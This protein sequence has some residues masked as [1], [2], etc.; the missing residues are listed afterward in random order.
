MDFAIHQPSFIPWPG[1]FFKAQ[2]TDILI[3]LDSVQFPRGFSW[4]NRNRIK[5]PVGEIWLT[6]PVLKKGLGLQA[7]NQVMLLPDERWRR[8]HLNT[9][10]HCYKNAPYFETLFA[11][12]KT[13]Y[14]KSDQWS[15]MNIDLIR[16]CDSVYKSGTK[17]V[18]QSELQVSGRAMEL[19]VKAARA[20]NGTRLVS[21][22][23]AR[24]H[25]D[26]TFLKKKGVKIK[27]I[28]YSHPVYPQLW[29]DF[30]KN[31]SILDLLFC[32]GPEAK[33]IVQKFNPGTHKISGG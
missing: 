18:K 15:E 22:T 7:I 30:I 13:I 14:Q 9:L 8:K 25:I 29:G 6:L 21:L 28:R 17:M 19:I 4:V 3:L 27:W 16:V 24:A 11:K 2:H 31:L 26:A 10:E 20:I 32:Y 23:S 5:G 33:T 12:I 1:F